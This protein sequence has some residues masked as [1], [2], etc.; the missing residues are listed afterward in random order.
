[1][2]NLYAWLK[3]Y[4]YTYD[5]RTARNDY[6]Y[7]VAA[8]EV[9]AATIEIIT[10]DINQLR[11][12][13]KQLENHLTRYNYH[14]FI[15]GRLNRD[16]Y[17]EYHKFYY[18]TSEKNAATLER[19]NIFADAARTECELLQHE[20]YKTGRHAEVNDATRAIMDKYGTMYNRSFIHV[21][22]A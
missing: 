22:A 1:M 15:D 11:K 6:F 13:Q 19:Y 14:I 18:V 3:K 16:I 10:K 21:I 5:A 9:E 12:M 2:K 8:V 4:N 20:Y 17:G 7:N